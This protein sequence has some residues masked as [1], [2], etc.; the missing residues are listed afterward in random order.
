MPDNIT[1]SPK[2]P[3]RTDGQSTT[4][5]APTP[6]QPSNAGRKRRSCLLCSKR[7]VKC[8]KQKPCRNCV[9]YGGECSF[10]AAKANHT[11]M[12][13]TPE[14]VEM[15]QRLE[16]VVQTLEPKD[17]DRQEPVPPEQTNSH[18]D[19]GD[20]ERLQ[21]PLPSP[22][23]EDIDATE[24]GSFDPA[25]V[26]DV[27][28]GPSDL[29]NTEGSSVVLP[30]HRGSDG[31]IIRDAGKD[32]YVRRW[33]WEDCNSEISSGS[34]TDE[35]RSDD[36]DFEDPVSNTFANL[37][38]KKPGGF[39][40]DDE[41]PL[42][43]RRILSILG[44]QKL[45]LWGIY[46]ERVEPLTKLLHLPSL[47]QAVTGHRLLDF[48]DGTR[49]IM[50]SVYYGAVTSLGEEECGQLFQSGQTRVLAVLRDEV[51]A[52][53]SKAMLIHTGDIQ[54]LQALVLYLIFLRHHEPRLSWNFSGLAV[55]LAQNFGIHREGS[56]F[57][58]STFDIEMR[59]R[60][61]W[62]IAVLDAPSAED[63]SGEYNLLEMSSFDSQPPRNLNDAQLYPAMLE[64]PPETRG[65]TE[66]TFTLA[67]CQIT[68]MYRC[69]ADSRKHC[70]NMRKSY[71]ELSRQERSD[72]IDSCEHEFSQRFF[73][74]YSSTN[75]LHWV[76]IVLT[77]MLFHK[78]RLH[79]CN[80]HDESG[81]LT[82]ATRKR[83]FAVAV[84]VIE[85]NCKLRT[86][87]RTRPWLWLFSSYTQWHAF[88]LVL[89]WLRTDP[90]C[91]G[92]RRAWQAIEKTIVLRWE[93]PPSLLSGQKPQQWRSVLRQLGKARS[94][95]QEAVDKRGRRGSHT[96]SER[97][98][99]ASASSLAST[100]CHAP[101]SSR[102][103]FAQPAGPYSS[104]SSSSSRHQNREQAPD[105]CPK[106]PPGPLTPPTTTTDISL[107]Q[108]PRTPG[109]GD[110]QNTNRMNS[111]Q[112]DE[113]T[114][115][116]PHPGLMM[117]DDTFS[118]EEFQD[119]QDFSFMEDYSLD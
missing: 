1:T 40:S 44:A 96:A 28:N 77:R 24:L 41:T 57:G 19:D 98:G 45:H 48:E 118:A 50:L 108:N 7:K 63:Y 78:V 115:L 60:L 111:Y 36:D 99:Q 64:Y 39:G 109:Q 27:Q 13:M 29:S 92:S 79:G 103:S 32:T 3:S 6:K 69:M 23:V 8:D 106:K 46:K 30:N 61:W 116:L 53:L 66:M 21:Y 88:S 18:N 76:T 25:M 117:I 62:Q 102:T 43:K 26:T 86:D 49:C 104:L 10:P 58:L 31:R 5:P 70:G 16:K 97:N 73:Q 80:P 11:Q 15:I 37:C 107:Q 100:T 56:L 119:L 47:E 42:A 38:A 65:I 95:R 52:M 33:F 14:L 75:A 90:L 9:K 12:V 114:D 113:I 54:P 74:D 34:A 105:V 91:K 68:N 51:E 89:H 67:R 87:P 22:M 85:L 17:G 59:R 83:L 35:D 20:Q 82:E 81:A 55:R 110:P 4:A 112:F 93:H 2:Q 94:A 71:A 72:W 101:S 84:E